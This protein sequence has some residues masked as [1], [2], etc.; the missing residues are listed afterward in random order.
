MRGLPGFHH[1]KVRYANFPKEAN[2]T[3]RDRI[4]DEE[5]NARACAIPMTYGGGMRFLPAFSGGD[6]YFRMAVPGKTPTAR[7][8]S[9]NLSAK[10]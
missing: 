4:T 5:K 8:H 10:C 1:A 6:T 9:S 2:F 7:I 3:V